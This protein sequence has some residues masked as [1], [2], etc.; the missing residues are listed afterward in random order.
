MVLPLANT[1][2]VLCNSESSLHRHYTEAGIWLPTV[3]TLDFVL[4][5]L[6]QLIWWIY[7]R[8]PESIDWRY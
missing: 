4:V 3:C 7:Q 8:P 2:L 6:Y 1:A 5:L